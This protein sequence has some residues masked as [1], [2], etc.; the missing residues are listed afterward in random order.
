[1]IGETVRVRRYRTDRFG[2]RAIELEYLI[3][4]CAFA[5]RS[6]TETNDRSE[7]LDG[8]AELYCPPWA[9]IQL[10]DV[11]ELPDGTRWEV[12]GLP[13]RWVHPWSHWKPGLVATLTIHRG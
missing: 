3:P 13:E 7:S 5:P 4:F 6:S 8:L 10:S 9:G 2:D 12:T 11:V 1:M